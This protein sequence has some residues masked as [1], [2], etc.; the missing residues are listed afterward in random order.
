V[1]L[2]AN[3]RNAKSTDHF[4]AESEK[5]V[6]RLLR[7]NLEIISLYLTED[8]FR[9]IEE[10]LPSHDQKSEC[11]VFIGSREEMEKIVGFSLHQ[12]ILAAAR[13]PKEKSMDRLLAEAKK[14]Q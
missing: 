8:Q 5:I 2:F 9:T 12:R 1:R 10:L 3:L 11:A 7:S 14:P 4:I 6:L 13:I